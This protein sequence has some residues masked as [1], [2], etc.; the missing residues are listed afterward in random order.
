MKD[1][2]DQLLDERCLVTFQTLKLCL[3]STAIYAPRR[4]LA[5]QV[6]E[7]MFTVTAP[8]YQM[9]IDGSYIIASVSVFGLHGGCNGVYWSWQRAI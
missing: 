1:S 6:I 2:A 7:A 5:K 3:F 8:D 9:D 4:H